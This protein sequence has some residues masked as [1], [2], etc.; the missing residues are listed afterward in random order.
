[1]RTLEGRSMTLE[2]PDP[3]TAFGRKPAT[4]ARSEWEEVTTQVKEALEGIGG[5]D[6]RAFRRRVGDGVLQVILSLN[7]ISPFGAGWHLSISFHDHK[8]RA[9]RYPRWDE[10]TDAKY[11]FLPDVEMAMFLPKPDDYVGYHATTFHLHEYEYPDNTKPY[12][13]LS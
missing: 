11:H 10:I 2:L 7:P 3:S 9:S 6:I 8:N 13:V 5:T 1:M 4:K 12:G